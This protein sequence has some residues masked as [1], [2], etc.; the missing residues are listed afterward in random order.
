MLWNV[1]LA[2]KLPREFQPE[3]FGRDIP[4][5]IVYGENISRFLIFGLALIMP[6]EIETNIQRKG[7]VL[8][9]FGLLLYFASWL[10]L[11]KFSHSKWSN[12]LFGFMAPAYTPLFWLTGIGLVGNSFYFKLLY[13]KWYFFLISIVFLIFHNLHAFIIFARISE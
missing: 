12:S 1:L 3:I 13:K 11:I 2:G 9:I 4:V 8:Y 6:L 10:F 5:F 7:L